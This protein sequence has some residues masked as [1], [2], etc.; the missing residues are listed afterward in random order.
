MP[1][2]ERVG[3]TVLYVSDVDRAV[4]FYRDKLG[5]ETVRHDEKDGLAF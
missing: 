3:H 5:M 1:R 4:A 2:I